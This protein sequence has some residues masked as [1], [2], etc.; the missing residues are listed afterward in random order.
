MGLA[1]KPIM[2]ACTIRLSIIGA[3]QSIGSSELAVLVNKARLL[4]ELPGG[5]TVTGHSAVK[6]GGSG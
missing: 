3:L 2:N 5:S 6:Q 1:K 4:Q